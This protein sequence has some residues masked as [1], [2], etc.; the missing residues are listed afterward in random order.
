MG[1]RVDLVAGVTTMMT[2][3]I[4]GNPTLLKRH[5]RSRPTSLV[6]D[7]PCSYLDL[8]PATVHYDSGLRDTNFTPSIVF[9]DRPTENGEV[10]DRLDALV[11]AFTDHLDS[12]PHLVAGTAW[13]DGTWNEE[14]IPLSDETSAVGVRWTFGD[15]T[16]KD[17][18]S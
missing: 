15:I 16:F 11:D 7:W 10:T 3:F 18:R 5:F 1:N 6:T 9:V 12:Y 8:R 14:S 17:G 2:A 13:S 4:A